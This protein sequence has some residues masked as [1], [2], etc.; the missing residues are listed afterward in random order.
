MAKNNDVVGSKDWFEKSRKKAKQLAHSLTLEYV[1]LAKLLYLLDDTPVDNDP[2]APAVYTYWGYNSL[3]HYALDELGL[4]PRKLEY[5]YSIGYTLQVELSKAD[6]EWLE[7]FLMLGWTKVRELCRVIKVEQL[8]DWV[9]KAEQATFKEVQDMVTR[10]KA[11]LDK[12]ALNRLASS[13][14][15]TENKDPFAAPKIEQESIG[16]V[17]V[18]TIVTGADFNEAEAPA[19]S[20]ENTPAYLPTVPEPEKITV[21]SFSFY[22][23]QLKTVK[24]ALTRAKQ[25]SGSEKKSHNLSLICLEFLA[26]NDFNKA[27]ED[28]KLKFLARLEKHLGYKIVAADPDSFE[29]VYGM[30]TLEKVAE[31]MVKTPEYV[32][33]NR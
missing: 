4:L 29:P 17:E 24:E 1:E 20:V 19:M 16:G 31:S 27:D 8:M 18:E 25:L 6:P 3:K 15:V 28:Q 12:A 22:E 23:D 9:L 14:P 33:V 11:E 10:Y 26:T 30:Q 13:G 7:R 5:L 21:E 32:G 2:N